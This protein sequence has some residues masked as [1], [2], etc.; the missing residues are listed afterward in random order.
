MSIDIICDLYGVCTCTFVSNDEHIYTY[1]VVTE[2]T[3]TWLS[4]RNFG[5][6]STVASVLGEASVLLEPGANY[7]DRWWGEPGIHHGRDG[8]ALPPFG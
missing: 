5:P 3:P 6:K 8:Q 7:G 4:E 1:D 2:E